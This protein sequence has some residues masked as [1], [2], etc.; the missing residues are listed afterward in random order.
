MTALP[1]KA[2]I[3]QHDGHVRFV[4]KADTARIQKALRQRGA[5]IDNDELPDPVALQP[6]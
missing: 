4:P 2:D 5:P 1:P 3:V 6:A